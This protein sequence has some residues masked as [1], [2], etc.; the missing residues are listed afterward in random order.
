MDFRKAIAPRDNWGPKGFEDRR[1]Y[2][3]FMVEKGYM[4][5][6]EAERLNEAEKELRELEIKQKALEEA[7]E[8]QKPAAD[9]PEHGAAGEAAKAED[10][11]QPKP[12]ADAKGEQQK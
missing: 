1:R 10:K 3:L 5:A 7:G 12:L 4:K 9:K 2:R 8:A 11:E 6:E